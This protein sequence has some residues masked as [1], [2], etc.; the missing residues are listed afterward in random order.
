MPEASPLETPYDSGR[1]KLN[2]IGTH[3]LL[4]NEDGDNWLRTSHQTLPTLSTSNLTEER[5]PWSEEKGKSTPTSGR[6][7]RKRKT[8]S[9]IGWVLG[10]IGGARGVPGGAWC[11]KGKGGRENQ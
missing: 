7:G 5:N 9:R 4:R 3:N 2:G 10:E 11:R 6:G 8:M 1:K